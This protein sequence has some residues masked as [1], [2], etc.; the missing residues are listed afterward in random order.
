MTIETESISI[1]VTARN[2]FKNTIPVLLNILFSPKE[3]SQ[4]FKPFQ[5]PGT[6]L[7]KYWRALILPFTH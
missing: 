5:T 6:I 2:F 7:R 4:H 3:N 1:F